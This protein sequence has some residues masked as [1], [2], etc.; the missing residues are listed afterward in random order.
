MTEFRSEEWDIGDLSGWDKNPRDASK[1]D[2]ARLKLQIEGLKQYKPLLVTE[3]GV[4]LGGNMRL[5]VMKE[6][7]VQKVWVSVVH[8]PDEKTKLEYALSDND[9]AGFYLEDRL[10]DLVNAQPGID[11]S[12]FKV[13]LGTPVDLSA[14]L[15][16]ADPDVKE[17]SFDTTP[18]LETQTKLG[19]IF[20]LGDHRVMCGD[21]TKLEDVE[22]LLS[23][24]KADLVFTDPPYN[25]AYEGGTGLT[26]KNDDM[27]D[28]AFREFLTAAFKN[29]F[30]ALK[31]GCPI[32][33]AH[34][35]SEAYNFIGAFK[36][37]GFKFAQTI[38]WVKNALVLGRQDYQWKHEPILYGWKEGAAH[39][40]YGFYDK[41]TVIDEEADVQKLDKK[42][43]IEM[44]NHL[45]NEQK[46][47][48]VREDKPSRSGE[49]PTMKPLKL[50]SKFL[51]NSSRRDDM[52]LDLFGGSGSTLI[53]CEQSN[54]VCY[55]LELDPKYVDVIV[56][57]WEKFTGEK[58]EKI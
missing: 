24:A 6:M 35:S 5:R 2:L 47:D 49:H 44:I 22:K 42:A 38:V 43:L 9:R 45:R 32:Y 30:F 58:A 11:L 10:K 14:L 41:T 53:A 1:E 17:D 18:A 36:D 34:A 25:V 37:A 46:T 21:A 15:D 26:I 3:D 52:V 57:R 4:V 39:R 54:R 12:A 50:I 20:I 51:F 7:G 13:D 33:V 40:W 31:E 27:G 56:A 48:I 23:G 8:A 16:A 55:T 28:K 19:D 29:S